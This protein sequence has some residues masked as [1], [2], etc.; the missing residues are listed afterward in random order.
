MV[1][2][3]KTYQFMA[4]AAPTLIG[5]SQVTSMFKD[6]VNCLC[7]PQADA[8]EL[9]IA[10]KWAY[11]NQ[12]K[13]QLIGQKGYELYLSSFSQKVVNEKFA[14]MLKTLF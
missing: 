7:V 3:G 1:I 12:P 9:A 6:K 2:T 10:I 14:T 4:S 5:Q 8:K 13:L 11:E